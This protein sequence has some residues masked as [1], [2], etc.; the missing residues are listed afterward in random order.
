MF[1]LWIYIYIY[2]YRYAHTH[3]EIS[4]DSLS[5]YVLLLA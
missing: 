1:N 4:Q 5:L 2:R 3:K